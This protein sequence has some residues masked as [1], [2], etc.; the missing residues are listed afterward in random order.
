MYG[1]KY[2]CYMPQWVTQDMWKV[3][4][5]PHSLMFL[6]L[7]DAKV[8]PHVF[9]TTDNFFEIKFNFNPNAS[10]NNWSSDLIILTFSKIFHP[11]LKY[12][13]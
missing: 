5:P 1:W 11:K 12:R 7:G 6:L 10:S 8:L 4:D 2:K 3:A 9:P 13:P